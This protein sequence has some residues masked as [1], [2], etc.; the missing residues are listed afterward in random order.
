M[1]QSVDKM[2]EFN[3][4]DVNIILML[5]DDAVN[6]R[7]RQL[8]HMD[9]LNIDELASSDDELSKALKMMRMLN[10]DLAE[11]ATRTVLEKYT[12]IA[13]EELIKMHNAAIKMHLL[14]SRI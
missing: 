7:T 1:S 6:Q 14:K 12:K 2:E 4:D 10:P 8:E 13:K 5:L 11:H 9:E 3:E